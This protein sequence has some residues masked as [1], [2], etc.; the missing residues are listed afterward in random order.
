[1]IK[2]ITWVS[3]LTGNQ[4]H[5]FWCTGQSPINWAILTGTHLILF[6]VLWL[7]HKGKWKKN[8]H[9]IC[10]QPHCVFGA[11]AD[12][13]ESEGWTDESP[14]FTE[15]WE[16]R[17]FKWWRRVPSRSIH[18]QSPLIIASCVVLFICGWGG[19]ENIFKYLY[20][21]NSVALKLHQHTFVNVGLILVLK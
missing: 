13:E 9:F 18:F 5:T 1:M 20:R 2:P 4:T 16:K 10:A 3:A 15:K 14:Q 8:I 12:V 6:Y 11:M 17:A 7:S 21:N 19:R